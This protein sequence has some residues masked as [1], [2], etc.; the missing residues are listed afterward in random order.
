MTARAHIQAEVDLV[1]VFAARAEARAILYV[2]GEYDLHEAVDVLQEN[3]AASCLVADI[4]QDA[5]QEIL[6]CAFGGYAA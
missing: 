3:A 4:G 5:V 6:A 2:A 1:A